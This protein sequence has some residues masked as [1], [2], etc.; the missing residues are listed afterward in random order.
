MTGEL[1]LVGILIARQQRAGNWEHMNSESSAS[2]TKRQYVAHY[3]DL[4][5]ERYRGFETKSAQILG[6]IVITETLIV[7]LTQTSTLD[8]V[9][10]TSVVV[11]GILLFASALFCVLILWPQALAYPGP[12]LEEAI[13]TL[14]SSEARDSEAQ[15]LNWYAEAARLIDPVLASKARLFK[16]ACGSAFL[17]IGSLLVALLKIAYEILKFLIGN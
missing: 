15:L 11:A 17:G 9:T 14:E 7:V 10:R 5:V 3:L 16:L 4:M 13:R 1:S 8:P 12:G 6:F 2:E